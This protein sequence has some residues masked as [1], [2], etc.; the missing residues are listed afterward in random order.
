[1]KPLP[2]SLDLAV[3]G[4]GQ[5][6]ALIDQ[7]GAI[8]WSC[9]PRP[10]AEPVF[11][12]LLATPAKPAYAAA[13]AVE[14]QGFKRATQQYERNTAIVVT[15]LYDANGGAVRVTDFCPRF[16]QLGRMFHPVMIVRIVEPLAGRPLVRLHCKPYGA[17]GAHELRARRGSNHL[18]YTATAIDLRLTSDCPL[19]AL[20]DDR[21]FVVT[22]SFALIFGNDEAPD[23]SVLRLSLRMLEST[24]EYWH[25]WV[26]SLAIPFGWQD[27]VIRAA[28]TLKLCTYED[29]GA[30]LAALTTSIPEAANSG[31]NWDYRYCWLRDSYF[32]VQALNRLGT[33]ATMEAYLRF[34]LNIA[35]AGNGKAPQPLYSVTGVA[36]LD[37]SSVDSLDGYRGMGPVRIGNAAYTQLQHDTYGAVIL[38]VS[39]AFFDSRL[40][41]PGN[42]DLFVELEIMGRHAVASFGKPDAGIWEFRERAQAH[43]YSSVMCWAAC[44]RLSRIA[45]RLAL[46]ARASYWR[47]QADRIKVAILKAAWNRQQQSFVSH[48]G[49]KHVDASLLLIPEVGFLP[50][51]DPRF[52][53]TLARIEKDLRRGPY[54]M[55]YAEVDDFGAPE[56]AFNICTF[57]YINALAATGRKPEARELFEHMLSRRTSAGLLSEDMHLATGEAWG[58]YPQ[59]YSLVG[60]IECAQRLSPTWEQAL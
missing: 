60:I 51:D 30:V 34:I 8:V 7:R 35:A 46:R 4:N 12:R 11:A 5:I 53:K 58:N 14:M 52:L 9:M 39:Q 21:P 32:V 56:S 59:T 25:E 6:N 16:R 19:T 43:T 47:R 31:R 48:H 50:A 20:T 42:R 45:V 1:M 40:L 33:T 10:D 3:I 57:W 26:R 44:D 29:S 24:R 36:A 55:R 37:E 2:A 41:N 49:G 38:A 13:F 27:E 54:L 22:E 17:Y 18:R 28:V 15:E 23:D